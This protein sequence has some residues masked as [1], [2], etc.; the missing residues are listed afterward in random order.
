MNE[1]ALARIAVG[2]RLPE[3]QAPS[4]DGLKVKVPRQPR[5]TE[6][7]LLER[8]EEMRYR[9][10]TRQPRKRGEKLGENDE[11]IVDLIGYSKGKLVPFSIFERF[12]VRPG[13]NEEILGLHE[14]LVGETIGSD[15]LVELMI[16]QTHPMQELRGKPVVFSV[17]IVEAAAL[18][19]PTLESKEFIKA[20][21]LGNTFEEA[22]EGI[23]NQWHAEQATI[24]EG[25][26]LAALLEQVAA[27]ANV[28]ID[29]ALVDK[30]IGR[31]WRLQEAPLLTRLN[32]P[33]DQQ[34][35][36][37]SAWLSDPHI[38]GEVE[39]H[40]KTTLVLRSI[41]EKEKLASVPE[42]RELMDGMLRDDEID[43]AQMRAETKKNG[44]Q[45]QEQRF[46][47]ALVYLRAAEYVLSRATI[48]Q[49]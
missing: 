23:A 12:V 3:V 7:Q 38:R 27:R 24:L 20:V 13:E 22:L 19:L 49:A 2:A 14:T 46:T 17:R 36:A 5:L 31:R 10:A 48:E 25:N 41:I 34:D 16:P 28:T 33:V 29:S 45:A 9:V 6:W 35:A 43:P 44:D 32:L 40:I 18:T 8:V 4:L 11:I 39:R 26:A 30:E 37:L 42:L 1:S 21:N 47:E 15:V